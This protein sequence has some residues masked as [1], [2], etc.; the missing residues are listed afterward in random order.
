MKTLSDWLIKRYHQSKGDGILWTFE[1][2]DTTGKA[3]L[4]GAATIGVGSLGLLIWSITRLIT[5][6]IN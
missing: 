3:N 1:K 4:I 5:M 6:A 2:S